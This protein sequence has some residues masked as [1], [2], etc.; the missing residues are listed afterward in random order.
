MKREIVYFRAD[1]NSKIG[2]GHFF[3]CLALAE[4]IAE[5]YNPVFLLH[6]SNEF[7][8]R[9]LRFRSFKSF[10][11]K[12]DDP[13][14]LANKFL[15]NASKIVLDG[16]DFGT[17]YQ[18]VIKNSGAHLVYIDDLH[19]WPIL[20][21]VVVNHAPGI[22]ANAYASIT[23]SGTK[24]FLGLSYALIREHFIK[25]SAI[26]RSEKK[27][28][29]V[30]VCMGGTDLR[31]EIEQIVSVLLKQPNL[32]QVTVITPFPIGPHNDSRVVVL[33]NQTGEG[34]AEL[35]RSHQVII[36]PPSTIS[37]EAFY[38][39]MC[40]ALLQFASNQQDILC[41]LLSYN[42]VASLGLASELTPAKL[43][44]LQ[45]VFSSWESQSV[46]AQSFPLSFDRRNFLNIFES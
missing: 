28:D 2:Y 19:A 17:N 8:S 3:R 31:T 36:C 14:L 5:T 24:F 32:R 9:Q 18:T 21:D 7:V 20:A 39:R 46:L 12:S 23:K 37:I 13:T 34:M 26:V 22:Q 45:Q 44:G 40:I 27:I 43:W 15:N 4:C 33:A 42:N 25:N 11:L 1:G 16:Y 10:H 38:S 30:L 35:M 29:R 6:D 41:G